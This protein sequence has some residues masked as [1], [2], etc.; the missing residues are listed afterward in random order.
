M[1]E[2]HFTKKEIYNSFDICHSPEKGKQDRDKDRMV[3]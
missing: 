1:I 2:I 3:M